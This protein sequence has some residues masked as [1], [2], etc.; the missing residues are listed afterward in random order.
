MHD[1]IWSEVKS[2]TIQYR[3]NATTKHTNI[4]PIKYLSF[5]W[6]SQTYKEDI[7]IIY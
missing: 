3:P 4:G 6:T 7:F 2:A 5:N 1:A